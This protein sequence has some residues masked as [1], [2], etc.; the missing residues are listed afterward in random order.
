MPSQIPGALIL[1]IRIR[2]SRKGNEKTD[3]QKTKKGQNNVEISDSIR[4]I[5][6]FS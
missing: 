3:T 4:V 2:Q 1:E 5:G 6:N